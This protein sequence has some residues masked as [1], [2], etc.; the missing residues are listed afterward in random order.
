MALHPLRI[1][2]ADD[3]ADVAH[4]KTERVL[5]VEIGRVKPRPLG[6]RPFRR[7][8][9]RPLAPGNV[10]RKQRRRKN[11]EDLEHFGASGD[12]QVLPRNP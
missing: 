5:R 2:V 9:P 8:L 11:D 3:N 1:V 4:L 7:G 10:G 12:S 6:I